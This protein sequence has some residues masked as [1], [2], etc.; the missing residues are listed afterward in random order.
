MRCEV[1]SG[2]PS[3]Y[4]L[5]RAG[6][7]KDSTRPAPRAVPPLPLAGEGWGEGKLESTPQECSPGLL[8]FAAELR[9]SRIES[10]DTRCAPT[11]A[12]VRDLPADGPRAAHRRAPRS[13]AL[14]RKRNRPRIVRWVPDGGID[15]RSAVDL[16][17]STRG[18]VRHRSRPRVIRVRL[19]G[20]RSCRKRA[21]T[22]PSP[23][24]G[25]GEQHAC[26]MREA[27]RRNRTQ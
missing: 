22:L 12:Y 26:E 24:S 2:L 15:S 10:H 17:S 21:L 16:A 18:A 1:C 19:R 4:P 27:S 23:A 11:I 25:R 8:Q 5:P 3:P 6:E 14:A 13:I 20:A 9:D 7:G